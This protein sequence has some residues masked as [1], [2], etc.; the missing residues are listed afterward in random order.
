MTDF[1]YRAATAEGRIETGEVF[2]AS[3]DDALRLLEERR[4]TVFELQERKQSAG[5]GLSLR[6]KSVGHTDLVVLIRELATLANSGIS[7]ANAL[8]TLKDANKETPLFVPMDK[9]LAAIHG[10]DEF[11]SAL[12]KAELPL[13]EYAV[14]MVRAGEATGNLG[15]ALS[16]CAEQMEFD[17]RMRAQTREAL[18]YPTILVS[19]GT[20]AVLFI[21]S[22]VVPRFASILKGRIDSLPWISEFVL[23][24][25]L[26]FNANFWFILGAGACLAGLFVIAVR[27]DAVR[28]LSLEFAAQL[29]VLGDW[30]RSGETARWTSA[31]AMLLQSRVPILGALELTAGS[32]RLSETVE[33]LNEVRSAVSRGKRMSQAVE[34]QRL[35]EPTSLS[36][37]RVGEQSGELGNML[38]HV[39]H[40]WSEKNQSVQRK[41]VALVEPMSILL[42]GVIIGF[43]MVGVVMA[44]ASLTEVKL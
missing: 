17:Q 30:I 7:L 25:G 43:V 36:M 14:A 40:Y 12:G 37:I 44:M 10:G 3:S 33:R 16:R 4:L 19:T 18:I 1:V 41:V 26:F 13:P 31:L 5:A 9:M 34:E 20:L 35:L 6:R 23:K 29:P 11:S 8:E 42:L 22:F 21:F 28:K 15:M 39:A 27:N 24:T 38:Q 2:A 32:V